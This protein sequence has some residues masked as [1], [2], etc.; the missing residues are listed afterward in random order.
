[1][2]YAVMRLAVLS[3]GR[4][5]IQSVNGADQFSRQKIG[6]KHA[7]ATNAR[8]TLT[9]EQENEIRRVKAYFPYRVVCGVIDKDTG[10]FNVYANVTRH[11]SNRLIREG[12]EV[13]MYD[14]AK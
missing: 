2:V 13:Y 6:F 10:E 14:N 7:A 8:R 1:M 12:H 4:I 3:H 11:T 9:T 5:A